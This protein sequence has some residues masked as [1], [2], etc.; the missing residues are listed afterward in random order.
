M[1]VLSW[2]LPAPSFGDGL[3]T[4]PTSLWIDNSEM[5]GV[6]EVVFIYTRAD[7]EGTSNKITKRKRKE[8]KEEKLCGKDFTINKNPEMPAVVEVVFIYTRGDLEGTPNTITKGKNKKWKEKKL[9]GK[10]FTINK[11]NLEYVKT[12]D[13][14]SIMPLYYP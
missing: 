13:V 14:K 2:V 4:G 6:I 11:N 8:W 1:K 7:L 12:I 10:D 3:S 5:A 9:C